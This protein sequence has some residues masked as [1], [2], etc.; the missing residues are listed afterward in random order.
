VK[1]V[2]LDVNV[3][4]DLV[5]ARAPF[6]ASAVALWAG[7]EQGRLEI[8]LPGHGVTTVFYLAARERGN[9]FAARVIEDLLAVPSIAPVDGP[10]LRRALALGWPDF[11]DAVCAAAAEA[12]RCDFLVT[13]DPKGYRRSPVPVVDAPTAL[14]LIA[15][16]PD[17]GDVRERPAVAYG[18]RSRRRSPLRGAPSPR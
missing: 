9:A 1:R 4:L 16:D 2:L 8:V 7:A 18:T 12:A 13:R 3:I 17:A 14:S 11:E 10:V 6:S 5:L 15:T